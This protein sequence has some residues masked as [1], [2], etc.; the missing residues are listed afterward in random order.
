MSG[1]VEVVHIGGYTAQSG[2]RGSGIV[3]ARR[4]PATGA[5]TPLGTVATTPSPSFLARHPTQ[6]VLYAVNELTD[7]EVSA[8]QVG[9]DGALDPLGTWS[10][11][12][13]E[14]CH[15]AVLPDGG[16]L[17]AANY[18]GGSVAVFP[19]DARGVPGE[20]TDLV[21]HEGHGPDPERQERAHTHMVSPGP[22]RGPLLAVDLGTDSVYRYDLDGAS[23]RLVPRGPRIRTAPGVGPRHLARHPDGRRCYLVGELDASVTAYELT[24]D[25]AL[26]Q[27]GRI[28]ASERA[29]HVQPSEVAVAPD[30]R[31]LYVANRGVGTIAVF[32]LAGELPELVA[33]VDTGGEWPRH[34]ALIGEHLY[35]AD[36]RADMVRVFGRDAGTGVPAPIGEPVPVPS[37]T[38]VLPWAAQPRG[39]TRG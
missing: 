2:G 22:G 39:E 3:A 20:R 23:G 5:L 7:G 8:W 30:G 31:F 11:G 19:L 1:Q 17:V 4:D 33:E 27:R 6:P 26:H 9:P 28:E 16:H 32:D 12:G 37:P 38:C 34:F 35:V 15:L 10:T 21:V 13:A 14:P 24:D 18:G 36:E 25:G 29:G